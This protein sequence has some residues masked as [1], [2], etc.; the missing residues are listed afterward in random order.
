MLYETL[1]AGAYGAAVVLELT[2][3]ITPARLMQ[4]RAV[5]ELALHML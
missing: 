1:A 2:S 3:E 4:M 5:V